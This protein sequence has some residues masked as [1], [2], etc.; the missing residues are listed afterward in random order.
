MERGCLKLENLGVCVEAFDSTDFELADSPFLETI[1]YL[2]GRPEGR[3]WLPDRERPTA[4]VDEFIRGTLEE[5]DADEEAPD[6]HEAD[7]SEAPSLSE[8]SLGPVYERLFG[9]FREALA[10]YLGTDSPEALARMRNCWI[11]WLEA[12]GGLEFASLDWVGA[13][14]E[15]KR[16][17]EAYELYV[18][19][20]KRVSLD[21]R[22]KAA[23][24]QWLQMGFVVSG[25]DERAMELSADIRWAKEWREQSH[26][27]FAYHLAHG[28]PDK[29]FPWL[30]DIE[31]AHE[32]LE[33][34]LLALLRYALLPVEAPHRERA[35]ACL[36]AFAAT[37]GDLSGYHRS[38]K[39]DE[40]ENPRERARQQELA[41]P[42]TILLR[43]IF[44]DE[45]VEDSE[46][47]EE[48]EAPFLNSSE[49]CKVFLGLTQDIVRLRLGRSAGA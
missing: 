27:I 21:S 15:A 46:N 9:E 44:G 20:R 10:D 36:E 2:D 42:E 8:P 41:E 19:G 18:S 30:F 24:L 5:E 25:D 38:L 35:R 31:Y 39:T 47:D 33:Q 17:R 28:R 34:E 1:A 48:E 12:G 4:V 11:E 40:N 16:A 29:A 22:V 43:A 6:E 3:N 14:L 23:I 32:R 26:D 49:C 45:A 13:L 37:D 7:A